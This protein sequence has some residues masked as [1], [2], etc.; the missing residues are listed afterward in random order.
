ML[1]NKIDEK[2]SFSLL[3]V[4]IVISLAVIIFGGIIALQ[5][6]FAKR[7]QLEY[8]AVKLV[9]DLRQAQQYAYSQR[10]G[11]KDST[12][13]AYKYYGVHFFPNVGEDDNNDATKDRE[14]WKIVRYEP[15]AGVDPDEMDAAQSGHLDIDRYTVIKG[16]E[17]ADNPEFLEK[18]YFAKGVRLDDNSPFQAYV[19]APILDRKTRFA[20]VM[21]FL[22][23]AINHL[24]IINAEAGMALNSVVFTPKGSAT[25]DGVNLIED[26]EAFI[27]LYGFGNTKTINIASLTGHIGLE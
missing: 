16:S 1:L 13:Y 6:P 26:Y 17:A 15:P 20:R 3:E 14:G 8:S 5:G 27:I 4:V 22:I 23:S 18:T 25:S 12:E 21:E 7:Q 19:A 9:G 24:K 2:R 10:V 11:I